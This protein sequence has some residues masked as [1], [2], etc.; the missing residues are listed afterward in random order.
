MKFWLCQGKLMSSKCLTKLPMKS[1][2]VRLK[3][4]LLT[5][6]LK[7][8]LQDVMLKHKGSNTGSHVLL[9]QQLQAATLKQ[10]NKQ[11]KGR[12]HWFVQTWIPELRQ[13]GEWRIFIL[14]GKIIEI[15][16]TQPQNKGQH[17]DLS[18]GVLRGSWSLEELMSVES[19]SLLLIVS[20]IIQPRKALQRQP[21]IV[22]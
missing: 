14:D 9:P 2:T 5:S 19:N 7:H 18:I 1:L 6:P 15:V 11:L 20:L 3:T 16:I 22:E 12:F 4:T 17:D 13:F 8:L 21:T 10:L